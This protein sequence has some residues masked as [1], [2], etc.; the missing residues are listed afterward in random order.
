MSMLA[1]DECRQG[2]VEA[3]RRNTAAGLLTAEAL[4]GMHL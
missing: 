2:G 3:I 1:L 4:W